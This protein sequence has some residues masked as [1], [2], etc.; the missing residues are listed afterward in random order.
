MQVKLAGIGAVEDVLPG[1]CS[2]EVDSIRTQRLP[3]SCPHI[4]CD[5]GAGEGLPVWR[6]EKSHKSSQKINEEDDQLSLGSSNMED[7]MMQ[8]ELAPSGDA[9]LDLI[10]KELRDFRKDSNQQL[11][12]IK[13]DINKIHQRMEEAEEQINT[14]ETR[15]QS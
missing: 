4:S 7:D 5:E 3:T 10:L 9:N 6:G 1:S 11:I 13:E 2:E 15:I 12:G 14:A 8:D